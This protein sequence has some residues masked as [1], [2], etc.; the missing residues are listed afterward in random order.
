MFEKEDLNI[1]IEHGMTSTDFLDVKL[2]LE[3]DEYRPFRKS[4]DFPEYIDV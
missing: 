1:T 2:N 4:N 3:K